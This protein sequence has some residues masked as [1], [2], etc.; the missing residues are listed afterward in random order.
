MTKTIQKNLF[1]SNEQLHE[2]EIIV[3]ELIKSKNLNDALIGVSK[4]FTVKRKKIQLST[5][6]IKE[7]QQQHSE[8][9]ELLNEYLKD[10]YEDETNTIKTQQINEEEV[11]IEITQ[12]RD[13]DQHSIYVSDIEFTSNHLSV[14]EIFLKNN[15]SVPQIEIEIF[16]KSKGVFKNQLIES[17]NEVCY[18]K[19]DDV[20]IEEEDEY[21]TLN[22]NYHQIILA[23]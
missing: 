4:I 18:E 15:F 21:Y 14:I 23:K 5:S 13:E 10:E 1:N 3:S 19:L 20:L 2:F 17:I 6:S 12:K 11:K 22:P 16:A 8:T 9:V 7:V